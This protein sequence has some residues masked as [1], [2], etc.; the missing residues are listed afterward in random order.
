[1]RYWR[2]W[3]IGLVFAIAGLFFARAGEGAVKALV[4]AP[5]QAT[6]VLSVFRYLPGILEKIND[7]R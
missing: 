3:L 6:L 1:M 7:V 4:L 5:V 2:V